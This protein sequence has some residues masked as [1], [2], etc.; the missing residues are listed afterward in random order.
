V[1]DVE[2]GEAVESLDVVDA[3]TESAQV[4][5]RSNSST[6]KKAQFQLFVVQPLKK[7]CI[8]PWSM[9]PISISV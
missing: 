1:A 3:H 8:S 4:K 6:S 7:S 2:N 5:A 9:L